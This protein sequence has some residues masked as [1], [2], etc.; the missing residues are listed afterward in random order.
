MTIIS[1][2][3]WGGRVHET[4]VAFLEK[5]RSTTDI[6]CFQEVDDSPPEH[7]KDNEGARLNLFS[8]LKEVLSDHIG[9]FAP[10]VPGIGMA[11]FVRKTIAVAN[12]SFSTVLATEEMTEKFIPRVLQYISI[13]QP[14]LSIYNF[15]GVPKSDKLDT[16]ARKFQSDRILE[17]LSRDAFSKILIGDFNLRPETNSLR[18]FE[19]GMRNLVVESGCA[20]TRSSLYELRAVQ[21][22]ADYA[23]ASPGIEVKDFQVLPDEVSDHLALQLIFE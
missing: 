18:A 4:F 2:N 23:F 1:L 5:H 6:F 17:V 15:H 11:T 10:Q 9:F 16:P 12:A 20:T 3:T 13:Q 21:P 14:V 19:K 8:E 22:F 7:L